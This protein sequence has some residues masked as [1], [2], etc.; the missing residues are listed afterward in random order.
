M[1]IRR[2]WQI[3]MRYWIPVAILTLVGLI[4]AYTYYKSSPPTYQ[5]VTT[6]D[7]VQTPSPNDAYSGVYANQSSEFAADEFV[8]VVTGNVFMSRVSDKLKEV[9]YNIP[10]SDLTGMVTLE[11]KDRVLT[12]TVGS[13]NSDK[14]VQIARTIA[15]TLRDNASDFVKRAVNATI[16]NMPE[17]AGI[18]GGRT[19]LLA[20]VRVIAG[21]LAGIGLAFLI[22]YLDNSIKTKPE[23]EEVLDLPVLAAIPAYKAKPGLTVAPAISQPSGPSVLVSQAEEDRDKERLSSR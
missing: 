4:T 2:Y 11:S 19:L 7:I 1:E 17:N 18:S 23:A 6:V 21:L 22:A 13:D 9:N 5:A 20:A 14:S 8:K 16:L 15:T 12:I 10:A 3:I